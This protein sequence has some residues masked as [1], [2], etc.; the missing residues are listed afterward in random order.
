MKAIQIEKFGN[1][2][3]VVRAV[4]IAERDMRHQQTLMKNTLAIPETFLGVGYTKAREFL[5]V[6]KPE[7]LSF[8]HGAALP[9]CFLSAFASLSGTVRA[10]DTV[11]IPGGGGGVGHLAVQMAARVLRAGLV[12]SSG[13]T[14]QSIALARQSGAHHVFDYKRD[15]IAAEIARLTGG[16]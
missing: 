6:P 16:R 8:L 4:D 9:M 15:D 13:S 12:I 14:P 2:T 5:T 7:S 1:R 11:Y 10:G 3:E